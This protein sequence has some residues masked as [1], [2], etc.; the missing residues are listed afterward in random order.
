MWERFSYYGMRSL[1]ILFLT[2][3]V[4]QGG[5]GMS[6]V[7]ASAIY[8]LYTAGVY[9]A[10][11]PG[12]W[13]ADRILGHRHAVFVGGV[14]IALGHFSMAFGLEA[15]FYLGL[16]LI[17]I[18]TGLLKPNVSA[19]VGDLYPEAGARRDAGFSVFYSGINLGATLGPILCGPLGEQ[20]NWHLGFAAAGVGMVF[21]LIQYRLGYQ[22]LGSA[23]TREINPAS[24]GQAVRILFAGIGL[25][26][27][28]A[29][30]LTILASRDVISV[31]GT[32]F[33]ESLGWVIVA[34]AVIYFVYQLTRKEFTAVEK[35]RIGTIFV[36]FIA[37]CLFWSGFEQAGSSLNI[38]TRDFTNRSIFGYEIPT[39]PFQAINATM[40]IILAPVFGSLWVRLGQRQPSIP[41][42]FALGLI[43]LG[44]GF[45]VM[46]WASTYVGDVTPGD[47]NTPRVHMG[48][49]IATYFFHT[50]GELCLSPVGL[51][52]MTKLSPDKLVGQMMGIWFLATSLGNLMAGLLAGRMATMGLVDLFGAIALWTIAA[53]LVLLVFSRP[54]R[55]LMGGVN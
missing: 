7:T 6:V 25:V 44:V 35:K 11:L 40:I 14:I 34:I 3:A 53:G 23:G 28:L 33:A 29:A 18:G 17:V 47:P 52:A 38:F 54:I 10:G 1:L 46:A 32:G 51:S 31:T 9:M 55:N 20:V 8:G 12:G 39:T 19:I 41:A 5:F 4:E 13:V 24:R 45:V 50:T 21:G 27:I 30:V 43:Q 15:T 37:A 16:C 48:W 26:V 42:K 2:A 36:L 22:R 49:L